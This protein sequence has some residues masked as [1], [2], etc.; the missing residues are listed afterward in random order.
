[1]EKIKVGIIGPGNIGSDLMYKVMKSKHL[2]MHLMAGIVESEGIKRAAGLGFK[3]SLEGVDAVAADP[4]IKIV[5][6]AT[7]AKAHLHNASILKAAGKIVLD[8]TPAA[9][10][11]YVVPCVNL[12]NLA[13]VDNFNMVTC[14]GQATIPIAYAI[15]R[16]A[17]CEYAEIVACLSSKSA[18][19]GTRANIDEFTQTTRKA[20]EIVGGADK[21]K[22]IIVLNPSEPPIM[23]TNTIYCLVKNPDEKKI[24]ESVNDIVKQVQ[25]YVPGY[26]LRFPPVVDGNKVTVIVQIEGAGDFLPT[27]SGNL[28]IIN[29]AAVAVAE[30]VA[31]NL[32]SREG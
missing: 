18:G 6:D 1:M 27:Y 7:S 21:A 4:D 8:M 16:V 22:A 29:Q 10:G 3:T 19:P 15:N 32:L 5:F 12:D 11:P 14:G 9:V 17:D 23:M 24:I 13:H 26:K 20:L 2:Q 25:A 28:D 31:E 30:K